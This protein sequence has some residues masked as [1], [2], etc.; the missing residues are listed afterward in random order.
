MRRAVTGIRCIA[1]AYKKIGAHSKADATTF[2]INL[3]LL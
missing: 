1:L 2:A 3:G